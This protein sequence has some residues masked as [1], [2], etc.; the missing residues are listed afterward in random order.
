MAVATTIKALIRAVETGTADLATPAATHELSLSDTLATGTSNGQADKVWSDTRTLAASATEDLDLAGALAAALGGTAVF[1]EVVAVMVIA[2]AA[3]T[4]NVVVGNGTAP[5]I[6]GPFGAAG[7]NTIVL[8]PGACFLW[9]S[10][11]NPAAAVTATTA[12]ILKVANSGGTTGVTYSIVI[13]GR[14]A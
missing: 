1:V 9:F 8:Q 3:N 10:P 11:T 13:L 2:L 12:D 6:G 7:A 14:S 4:N 5:V